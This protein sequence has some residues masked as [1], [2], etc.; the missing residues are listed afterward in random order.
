MN[1]FSELSSVH[2]E[3]STMPNAVPRSPV[4]K[5]EAINN[6]FIRHPRQYPVQIKKK[7][8]WPWINKQADL[9]HSRVGVSVT[10]EHYIAAGTQVEIAIPLRSD[11]QVFYGT[12]VLVRELREGFELGLWLENRQDEARARIVEKICRTECELGQ[13]RASHLGKSAKID[14]RG[15]FHVVSKPILGH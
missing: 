15:W 1:T 4:E 11:T 9:P 7:R 2:V 5:I 13:P 10:S 6:D 8:N 12:V 14:L 3:P